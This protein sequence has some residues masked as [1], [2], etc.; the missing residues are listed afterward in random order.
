MRLSQIRSALLAVLAVAAPAVASGPSTL[1]EVNHSLRDRRVSITLQS[2]DVIKDV[3]GVVVAAATTSYRPSPASERRVSLPTGDIAAIRAR[4]H[5]FRHSVYGGIAIGAGVGVGAMV[6]ESGC[7]GQ[8]FC[9]S[10]SETALAAAAA[11]LIGGAIGAVVGAAR[12]PAEVTLF[13]AP[14]DRYTALSA[15]EESTRAFGAHLAELARPDG[16]APPVRPEM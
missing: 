11:T 12:H 16:P 14:V 3:T 2:G 13:E 1:G 5:V 4:E 7:D 8:M 6:A 15:D 9:P 10:E